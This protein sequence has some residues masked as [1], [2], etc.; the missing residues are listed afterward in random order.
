VGVCEQNEPS[1]D[2]CLHSN[3]ATL[4]K[5]NIR[6]IKM[7]ADEAKGPMY[8]RS[9][10]E[11]QLYKGELYYLTIDSHMLFTMDWDENIIQ[12]LLI[13]PSEKPILT[14]YP[15]IWNGVSFE[16][17]VSNI[18]PPY[19]KFG[20]FDSK[21]KLPTQ[22]L[23]NYKRDENPKVPIPSV[24]W[25]GGFSFT[26]GRV[27]KEVP[28]DP[29]CLYVFLG[30]EISMA[31][32]L[33]TSGWDLFHPCINIVYHLSD[34]SYRPL[35]WERIHNSGVRSGVITKK[36]SEN[37]KKLHEI[38]LKRIRSLLFQFNDID[39]GKYGLGSERSLREF[40]K[41]AGVYLSRQ[42]FAKRAVY[43]LTK[44]ASSIELIYKKGNTEV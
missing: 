31:A 27:I 2:G 43:G 22:V 5:D 23:A 20:G 32:R 36:I 30:E 18:P 42:K 10:I 21:R 9:L 44:N 13:C 26:L 15:N 17:P 8:A 34:R 6:V 35:F 16:S 4:F 28:Y 19:L 29:N 41:Y 24:S 3:T 39:F 38:G 11:S 7:H 1:D 12:Q 40:E 25:A 33:F 14:C 37:R